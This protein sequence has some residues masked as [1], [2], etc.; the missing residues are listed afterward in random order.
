MVII[1]F[2]AALGTTALATHI[3]TFQLLLFI[4][5]FAIAVGQGTEILIG[6]MIGAG[7]KAEAYHRMF[8]S[9]KWSLAITLLMVILFV[10]LRE[11]LYDL[12][13]DDS[14]II[15]AG[16]TLL[17]ITIILEPGRTFN[18]VII[19][20]LRATGDAKFPVIIGIL[21]MWGISVPLAYLFGITLEFGLLG[22]YLAFVVDEW[23]RGLLMLFRWRSRVWMRMELESEN[24]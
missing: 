15:A 3:Y 14:Q 16:A 20:S 4:M 2:I 19:N 17:L 9:L 23:L 12:F 6:Q 21:S 8:D 11:P 18:L 5:L 22:I 10:A 1:G 24:V 7:N 13:T